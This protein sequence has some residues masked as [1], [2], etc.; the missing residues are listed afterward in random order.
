MDGSCG[1]LAGSESGDGTRLPVELW[2]PNRRKQRFER[3]PG[4]LRRLHVR[5]IW[6]D[7]FREW[8]VPS[9][10]DLRNVDLFRRYHHGHASVE[11]YLHSGSGQQLR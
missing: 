4:D 10:S 9:R 8:D 6:T 7:V 3:A 5:R 2:G 1:V 11:W